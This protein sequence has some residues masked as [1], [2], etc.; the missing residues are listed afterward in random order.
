[1]KGECYSGAVNGGS[2]AGQRHDRMLGWLL[3]AIKREEP[4]WSRY[5]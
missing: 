5:A 1:M 4:H 2:G 3:A